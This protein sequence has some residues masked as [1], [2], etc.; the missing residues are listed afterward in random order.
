SDRGV[1][2]NTSS[3][4]E[5]G[6]TSVS[7][8]SGLGTF[9]QTVSSLPA[10]T[11]IYFKAYATNSAGTSYSTESSFTTQVGFATVDSPT[12]ANIQATSADLGGT[13]S[14]DGGG[15][16]S[17]RGIVWNTTTP[18]ESGGTSVSMGSGL[19]TFSQ[20]VTG[21]PNGTLVYYRAY[22]TNESGTA[23]STVDSFT[24]SGP[25][26]VTSPTV[27]NI[28]HNSA[29]LG[30][31]ITDDGGN[32]ILQRGTVWNTT[33]SPVIETDNVDIEGGTTIGTFSQTVSL[34]SS[35]TIYYRAYATSSVG[36]GYSA[37][38]TFVTGSEPTIQASN[39]N[40]VR[41][42]G[43]GMTV[44]W[45][46]GNG[47]GS[48][49]V[50]RQTATAR[51]DPQDGDD[52]TGNPDFTLAPE[53]PVNSLNHVI[54][55]GA[56]SYLMFNGLTQSTSYTVSIYEYAGTGVATDYLQLNPAEATQITT[57]YA[58]H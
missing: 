8:G 26:V 36:T 55:K 7:M 56:S 17:D 13:V 21:L 46:R 28:T 45:T 10:G 39:V 25:P 16:V 33:G 1:V 51:T 47:D 9:S 54:Y 57:A 50:L 31:T 12:V 42:A 2:W 44:S 27:A 18:P 37:E 19:G 30:G 35:T 43:G 41:V 24:P 23:Y 48:I 15:T 14:S 58:I 38:D 3:P 5:S 29:D 40:F 22:A 11:L 6:G 20:N 53:L 52:Y 32:P 49:V 4:A 34:P